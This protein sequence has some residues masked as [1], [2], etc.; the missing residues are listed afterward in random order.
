MSRAVPGTR[1]GV[2]L[3]VPRAT[4]QALTA[5]QS[6]DVAG[7]T[8]TAKQSTRYLAIGASVTACIDDASQYDLDM[9]AGTSA[10]YENA[11]TRFNHSH[12]R[13]IVVRCQANNTDTLNLWRHGTGGSLE[14]LRFSAANTLQILTNNTARVTLT[15]PG[16]GASRA[17]LVVA[18]TS[19]ANPDTT[20]AA[21]A[22][23]ST[24]MVWN[25]DSGEYDA[26]SVAHPTKSLGS[27]Q[28]VWGAGDNVGTN[29]FTGIIT[30][31]LYENR[32]M[33]ATEIGADWVADLSTPLSAAHP[34]TSLQGLPP[35]SGILDAESH[36]HG[37]AAVWAC[38]ATR[39]LERRCLQ[40]LRNERLRIV[41]TWTN[42]LLT[43]ADAFIRGAPSDSDDRMSIAWLE[44]APVPD[45]CN[46]LWVRVHVRSYVTSGAAVPVRI[47]LYSFSKP[48]GALGFGGGGG[49][50][51]SYF[52]GTTVLEGYA[53]GRFVS[54]GTMPIAR[55]TGGI[56][57]GMTYLALALAVD[58]NNESGNDSAA[59]IE[60][61]AIHVVPYFRAG[62]AQ[63]PVHP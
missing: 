18:W 36:W 46:H 40:W 38:D 11:S 14:L 60:I 50:I 12:P 45:N 52:C 47:R 63:L 9:T 39:R 42:A 24:L 2:A 58:P 44:P 29:A 23:L 22:V 49:A 17:N 30:G 25:V 1:T 62:G 35:S 32:R 13:T 3:G 7:P 55:G 51:T 48:P 41:P 8:G 33:S 37:P 21:D 26:V 56:R 54:L 34:E 5:V 16:L 53:A 43:A 31:V 19:E 28:A 15:V 61:S 4:S 6:S 10:A 27:F 59:R 20:G 57:E